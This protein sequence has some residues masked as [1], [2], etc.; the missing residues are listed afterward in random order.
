[1]VLTMQS[2]QIPPS[3]RRAV[4]AMVLGTALAALGPSARAG[5]E[6]PAGAVQ[7]ISRYCTACWRNARLPNDRWGDCTQEVFERLLERVPTPRW[8]QVF[9]AEGAE[10]Q[11]F[12]RAI[13]TVKK[14]VQRD[15][16][17]ATRLPGEVADRRSPQAQQDRET[18]EELQRAIERTLSER[19]QR[20]VRRIC[21]GWSV[22]DIAGELG[23]TPARVSDEKYKAIHKLRTQFAM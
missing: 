18:H 21:E 11:E 20:I 13:D 5:E 8:P 9:E 19:Q 3:R 23:L 4:M 12:L 6:A 2:T 22:A 10:R 15:R 16:Q 7:D 1:M 14:R 17:R